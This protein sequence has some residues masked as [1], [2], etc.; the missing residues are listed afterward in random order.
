MAE[1]VGLGTP[2]VHQRQMWDNLPVSAQVP[3]AGLARDHTG[4]MFPQG[5]REGDRQA[6][7]HTPTQ[8]ER[9]GVL[10]SC[11]LRCTQSFLPLFSPFSLAYSLSIHLDPCVSPPW[12]LCLFADKHPNYLVTFFFTGLSFVAAIPKCETSDAAT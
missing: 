3:V 11:L 10:P 4:H 5:G 9:A 1:P 7:T 6:D 2:G 12:S 8:P